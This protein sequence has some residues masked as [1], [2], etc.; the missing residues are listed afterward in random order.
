MAPLSPS[1]LTVSLDGT[2]LPLSN[3]KHTALITRLTNAVHQT[4][5]Q[6]CRIANRHHDMREH[7]L[8]SL[9]HA[10]VL[11][12]FLYSLPY[13]FFSRTKVYK[14]ALSLPT[15]TTVA[16]L[17]SMSVHNSLTERTEA[18]R[19]AQLL[20]L[21]LTRRGHTLLSTLN[22]SPLTPLPNMHPEHHPSRRAPRASTLWR[23]YERQPAMA[24]V[25]AAPYRHYPALP[26][27]LLSHLILLP[28][29][30]APC[31][32]APNQSAAVGG[33]LVK[34]RAGSPTPAGDLGRGHRDWARPG[35]HNWQP[36]GHPQHCF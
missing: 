4:I 26:R 27:R 25:D 1:P 29:T 10:F 22:L 36:E 33:C 9:V 28:D 32:L 8:R 14:S 31:L 13:I 15:S 35:R 20:R 2:P 30:L 17:L 19:T 6:I 7:D 34:H 23:Q 11:N 18:H 12:R 5:R 21:S 3:S 24:Y 16:R